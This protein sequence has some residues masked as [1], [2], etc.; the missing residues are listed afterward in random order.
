MGSTKPVVARVTAFFATYPPQ[1][2]SQID[3]VISRLATVI[4]A[5]PSE[6][7]YICGLLNTP[8]TLAIGHVPRNAKTFLDNI[9]N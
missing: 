2:I 5:T 1:Q 3:A 9:T 7:I 4:I 6:I 8:K